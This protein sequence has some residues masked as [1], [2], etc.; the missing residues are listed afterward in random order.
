MKFS[1]P[2]FLVKIN[3]NCIK[4][5]RCISECSFQ[6]FTWEKDKIKI[7]HEKCVACHRC[8]L[9]CPAAAITVVKFPA[10]YKENYLWAQEII[11]DIWK[12]AD[13]G[14]KILTGTGNDR[15]Y[16]VLWD[17]ILLDASQVTN[18]SIDPLREPMELRTYLGKKPEKL[19]F[20]CNKN[21]EVKLTTVMEPQIKLETPIIFAGMSYGAVSL[22]VH[23]I[24]AK[25]AQELGTLMNTGEGGLPAELLPYKDNIVVQCAS[26]RFGVS[27]EYLNSCAAVEIKIGQGAKPGIGGHLPGEKV[28]EDISRTRMIPSGTDAISPAP[29]HDIYSIEDLK[30]LIYAI[31]EATRYKKPVGVKIAAVHNVAAI[32]SGVVRAGA[33][34]ITID[35]FRAGT[36]AAPK[37]IRDHVGIPIEIALAQ[38]DEQLR[39]EGIRHMASII[40]SGGIRNSADIIK[41]IALGAD[42]VAIGTAALIALGCHLCQKCYT[43]LCPWG[44]TTQ[45]PELI[46]RLN[47]NEGVLRVTNLVKAWN[48]EIKEILGALGINSIESL[49]GNRERLRGI[50]LD[51]VYLD[52]LGIKP[53]GR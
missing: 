50:D 9:Y 33:D 29:H 31:K 41:A 23:L 1:H 44:I 28:T 49:R 38:V 15:P 24:L 5:K 46:K 47:V 34:I 37:V 20:W 30:Q 16:P 11:K 13:T 42:A 21:G 22:N 45:K 18:P 48:L 27:L 4:C 35:G 14:G 40:A 12:Q 52:V 39:R 53:V 3:E 25:A 43:G 17:K 7:S 19:E 6:V 32:A 10:E 8:T 26:G 2:D 51:E 36:G